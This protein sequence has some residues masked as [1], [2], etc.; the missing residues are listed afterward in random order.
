MKIERQ[1]QGIL[2]TVFTERI[3]MQ[4]LEQKIMPHIV[5]EEGRADILLKTPKGKNL[6]FIELKDPTAT[7]G[8][9]VYDFPTIQRETK[10]AFKLDVKHFGMCNFVN[11]T[12][13]KADNISEE[14][15]SDESYFTTNE[16]ANL[17][18]DFSAYVQQKNYYHK[19]EK[20]A[21]FYIGKAVELLDTKTIKVKPIDEV[22]IIRTQSL[23]MAYVADIALEVWNL[24]Q[25]DKNFSKKVQEYTRKQQW[26]AP[27]ELSEIENLTFI[28]LLVLISKLI[29]YKTVYDNKAWTGLAPLKIPEN[30][31][32]AADLKNQIWAFFDEFKQATGNFDVLIGEPD[33]VIFELPF[34][35]DAV[36]EVVVQTVNSA[37]LYDFSKIE[38]DI[39]GR[40]FENLIR[41]EERHKLGQYFTPPNV[42]DLMLGFCITKGDEKVFDPSCGSGTFLVR[43]YERKRDISKK[44]HTFLIDEI[45]G[46]D[47]SNYPAYLSMLN[48]AIRKA[49]VASYPKILNKDFFSILP[50]KME[51]IHNQKGELK[52]A[53]LPKFDAIVGNPPYTRQEDIGTLQGTVS[54]DKIQGII[55]NEW[56]IIPS[57]RTSIYAYFFYHSTSFLKE[58][59]YLAFIV[60]NSWLDTDFGADLQ[61]FLCKNF[62]IEVI[63]DSEVERFFPSASVNTSIVIARKTKKPN[64]NHCVAF[65]YLQQTLADLIITAKGVNNLVKNIREFK[66][67]QGFKVRSVMQKILSDDSKWSKYLKAPQIYFDI[68]EKA[69]NKLVPLKE[70]AEVKF[71]LK[72]GA[73]D[74]FILE[75]VSNKLSEIEFQYAVNRPKKMETLEKLGVIAVMNGFNE[76]WLIEK[77]FIQPLLS[78]SKDVNK[79]VI[80]SQDVPYSVFICNKDKNTLE[81]DYPFAYKYIK[82]GERNSI[83]QRPSCANR[84]IWYD[85]GIKKLPDMSF[86]YMINDFGKTFLGKVFASSNLHCIFVK[87]EN[88][89]TIHYFLN[90]TISWFFQQLVIRANFGDG[91]G[92]LQTN[93]LAIFPVLGAGLEKLE[94]DLGKTRGYKEELGGNLEEF[95]SPKSLTSINPE[96]LKLDDK[97]LE[98]FG[99]TNKKEREKILLE[100]YQQTYGLIEQRLKKSKSLDTT[101]KARKK[102]D[103][104]AYIE[105]LKE[106]IIAKNIS[107]KNTITFARELVKLANKITANKGLQKKILET[108]WQEIF[109]ETFDLVQIEGKNQA[110]ISFEKKENQ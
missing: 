100:L 4:N 57:A 11:A 103:D 87:T 88:I 64:L 41:P 59:G 72:T 38:Y 85:L 47:L 99:Y 23:I 65:V 108:Y 54:K 20:I 78:S 1:L 34:I 73:D 105:I 79:Y 40:I 81:K 83:N 10:R 92:K 109:S 26:N 107:A 51:E 63:I 17:Q 55:K 53:L 66:T 104:G 33:D 90:S 77:E 95:V 13:L 42:I 2:G 76:L 7:D 74:F 15:F 14:S 60:S 22:F 62:E 45:Y 58:G 101:Q 67:V 16:I 31:N 3:K 82:V 28:A 19:L 52:R 8:K 98:L 36:I 56:G 91:V 70:V 9:T 24:Y 30:I 27:T 50:N 106:N 80:S 29:F 12:I 93:E 44:L 48:L 97:I 69:N 110:I 46:N 5:Q 37:Q 32:N 21:D 6:F 18:S 39:I 25:K 35:S 102:S 94:I 89:K 96:R 84:A 61:T 49:S 43:A 86:N 68:L 75:D 71:G